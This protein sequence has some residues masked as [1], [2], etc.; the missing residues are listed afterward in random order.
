MRRTLIGMTARIAARAGK[1][2]STLPGMV[3]RPKNALAQQLVLLA[4]TTRRVGRTNYDASADNL[5]LRQKLLS[6]QVYL[7]AVRQ[8]I[9]IVMA[10]LGPS[11]VNLP[12]HQVATE[13]ILKDQCRHAALITCGVVWTPL[14]PALWVAR[15]PPRRPSK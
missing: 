12:Q 1:S 10:D 11:D 13:Q 3:Q 15:V 9:P 14:V 4:M 5:L 6:G 7:S 8:P 2:R